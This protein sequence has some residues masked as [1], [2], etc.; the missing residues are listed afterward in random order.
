MSDD[1]FGD[2]RLLTFSDESPLFFVSESENGI[3]IT[4]SDSNLSILRIMD[5]SLTDIYSSV[6]DNQTLE[7]D[8]G[9]TNT[10]VARASMVSD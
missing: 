3:Y 6:V 4:Q 1:Y 5:F 8:H 7:I 10:A 9:F 2:A